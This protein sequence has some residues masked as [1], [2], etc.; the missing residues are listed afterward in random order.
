MADEV[1]D[2]GHGFVAQPLE[3]V[4]LARMRTR[5]RREPL[6]LSSLDAGVEHGAEPLRR[7]LIRGRD[8][9]QPDCALHSARLPGLR[10]AGAAHQAQL[11]R[12]AQ[13]VDRCARAAERLPG[14]GV[15]LEVRGV[16]PQQN[17]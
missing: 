6:D 9:E 5:E 15:R 1:E 11:W 10:R 4:G 3:Q 2:V 8:D 14:H 7:M 12:S 13:E 17:R 16:E